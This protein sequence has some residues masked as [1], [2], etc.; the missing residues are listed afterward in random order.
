MKRF[1]I[2][3]ALPLVIATTS[4]PADAKGCIKGAVVGAVAGHVAGHH[5]VI[6]A[7]TGCVVGHHLAKERERAAHAHAPGQNQT[8]GGQQSDAAPAAGQQ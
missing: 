5:A 1:L 6:G 4:V 3:A 8:Q 2:C 7:V